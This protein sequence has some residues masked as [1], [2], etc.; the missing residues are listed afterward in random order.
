VCRPF[1]YLVVLL[2]AG[3]AQAQLA[4]SFYHVAAIETKVLPNA[5]RLTIR[6]D[7][8]PQ[9]ALDTNEILD[10]GEGRYTPKAVTA[11]RIRMLQA[12]ALLPA[13]VPI[14]AY[15]VDAAF[16]TLGHGA[17]ASAGL[18][19]SDPAHPQVDIELRFFVPVTVKSFSTTG[20]YNELGFG[21]Y[22]GPREVSV[23]L[24]ADQ[25]SIVVTVMS[26]HADA[27]S[28]QRLR[29]SPPTGWQ[30]RLNVTALG[31]VAEAGNTRLRIDALHVPLVDLLSE[32]G[33]VAGIPL[34]AMPG[35][36]EI[37][38]SL[39]LRD[40]SIN[41]FIQSISAGYSLI[42]ESRDAAAG[43]GYSLGRVSSEP[44][45]ERL[46]LHNLTPEQ[47]RLLFPDFLLS[48]LRADKDGNAL[49]ISGSPRLVARIRHDLERLDQ[50]RPQVKM[51][52]SAWEIDADDESTLTLD[53]TRSLPRSTL[54]IA[55]EAGQISY[56]VHPEQARN[57]SLRLEALVARGRARLKARP[58]V[59]VA[60]GA[61]AS[62][63]LGQDRYITVLQQESGQQQ[64]QALNI[65]VGVTLDVT[66]RVGA[67]DDM[68]LTLNPKI[69][70]VDSIEIGTGLPTIGIRETSSTIRVG[71][72][73]T[74]VVSGLDND[75]EFDTRSHPEHLRAPN[76]RHTH[77]RTKL[78]VLVEAHKV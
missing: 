66:P 72:G 21:D 13:L 58:N 60:N 64:V 56:S 57:L 63:F 25:R 40:V 32:V 34:V 55:G 30:H 19:V 46:P 5:V 23:S 20:Q 44:N 45:I 28:E 53:F 33:R 74:V 50:P 41:E 77:E 2:L 43:G 6:T 68:T 15:P 14:G 27:N 16:V 70:T 24:G 36:G 75:L 7:G 8:T 18:G 61:A 73:D 51:T 17:S 35:V 38:I 78:I 4:T 12:R 67:A 26:D 37:D 9:F 1:I 59:T 62:L 11:F 39:L 29:R 10:T 65:P 31:D 22:L 47:A 52:V 54:D 42:V 71:T 69:S 48:R 76:R 49:L 3:P